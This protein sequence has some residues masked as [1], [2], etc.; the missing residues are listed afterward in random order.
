VFGVNGKDTPRGDWKLLELP[1]KNV[2]VE[3]CACDNI[4]TFSLVI[5]DKGVAYF[6]GINKKG[7]SGEGGT[8]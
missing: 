3:Y 2:K 4:G 8:N 7:E 6:G 5:S 1:D